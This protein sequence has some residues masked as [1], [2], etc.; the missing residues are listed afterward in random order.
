[1]NT[2]VYSWST[3]TL[4]YDQDGNGYVIYCT[5]DSTCTCSTASRASSTTP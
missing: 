4:V 5:L 2:Q 1:M 3:P